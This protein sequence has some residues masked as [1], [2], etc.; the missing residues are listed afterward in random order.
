GATS[1]SSSPAISEQQAAMR[2]GAA[3]LRLTV[4]G[5]SACPV[6]IMNRW[7]DLSGQYLLERYGMTEIGMA[8]S[9][10][11]QGERR[12]GTVGTPLPGVE[13]RLAPDGQLL[14]RGANVF[15]EYW[16][17][18]EATREAFDEE[19][20]YRTGDTAS[21]SGSP[22]YFTIEGRTSVDIMK[23]GGFKISA[24]Q[25]ESAIMEH[26][27]ISEVAVLGVPDETYGQMITA[28]L[29]VKSAAARPAVEELQRFCRER[30]APYQVP[31]RWQWVSALP[32]NA[33]GKVNKKELARL[34]L[35]GQ[36]PQ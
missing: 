22:P 24:L 7:R 27:A 4:S 15:T 8:L 16:G 13:A 34:L 23:S 17:R 28:L 36:L 5:S 14:V 11:Y 21:V 30:L 3:A 29:A 31:K 26:P 25:V 2:R 6:P 35:A 19:G 33:M 1:T 10:P 12:P 32:R 20:F 9:N 18:P